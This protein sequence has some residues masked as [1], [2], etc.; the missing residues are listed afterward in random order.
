MY[1]VKQFPFCGLSMLPRVLDDRAEA[2]DYAAEL[3]RR[4]RRQGFPVSI[5]NVGQS[6]EVG[7]PEG[8]AMV[9]DQCGTIE[10]VHQTFECTECDCEHETRDDARECC[11]EKEV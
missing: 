8:A 3:L 11:T 2:R 5:L 1:H 4:R 7:E 9:P 10:L 6:W